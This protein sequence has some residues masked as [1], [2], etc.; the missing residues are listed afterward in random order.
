MRHIKDIFSNGKKEK[1]LKKFTVTKHTQKQILKEEL[2]HKEDGNQR[3][4]KSTEKKK[5]Y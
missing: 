1:Q 3:K 4:L 5:E 2:R